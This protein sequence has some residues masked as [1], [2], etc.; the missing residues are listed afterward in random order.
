GYSLLGVDPDSVARFLDILERAHGLS[1]SAQTGSFTRT[2]DALSTLARVDYSPTERHTISLRGY[3]SGSEVANTLL[4]PLELLESGA[5]TS[6]RAYGVAGTLTSRLGTSWVNE[7]R[8]SVS[9]GGRDFTS[10]LAAPAGR[11]RVLSPLEE[12]GA[13]VT[14]LSFGGDPVPPGETSERSIEVADELSLLV[15]GTHRIKL[16]SSFAHTAFGQR[17]AVGSNGSFVFASLADLEAGRAT[18]FTRTLPGEATRGSGWSAALYLGDTWRP[19]EPLQLVYGVRV[20]GSGFGASPAYSPAA[21]S[22]FGLHTDRIPAEVHVSPRLG[23]SWFTDGDRPWS[24]RGGI[25]EFRGRTPFSLYA[26]VLNAGRGAGGDAFLSCVGEGRVPTTD[27]R[28]F[29]ADRS[30]V[31]TTCADGSAG[32]PASGG[33]PNVAAFSSGFRS[34]RSW[35][36]SLGYDATLRQRLTLSM[37]A[38]YILGVSQYGVRDLNLASAPAFTL[39]A[40]GGR[41]VFAP[42]AAIDP[43]TGTIPLFASRRDGRFAQA[44]EVHSGLRSETGALTVALNGMLSSIQTNF[45]LSYTLS[46]TRDQS[47]F[48]F[49]GPGSGFASTVTRGDPNRPGW[50]PGDEDRRH[51][52][53]A[54][55]GRPLGSAWEVSLIGRA[56]SGAPYTPRVAGDVNGD[57][58]SNDAAFVFDPASAADAGLGAAMQRLLE[59]APEHAAACLRANL[60]GIV[61]RNGCRTGWEHSLDVRVAYTPTIGSL[62]RRLSIGMDVGNVPAGLDLLLHGDRG[63][64]GW[65]QG[66]SLADDVLLHPRGFDPGTR[67]FRYEVNERFGQTGSRAALSGSPF[68][69]QLS[70][71]LAVGPNPGRD[72]WGGFIGL[73]LGGRDGAIRIVERLPPQTSPPAGAQPGAEQEG[74]LDRLIPRP[75]EGIL[76]L[77][78]TLGLSAEQAERLEA[79]RKALEETNLPIRAELGAAL[80]A[81]GGAPS[82]NPGAV[83]DKLGPRVNQGRTHVQDALDRARA[84]LTP[85]QWGRVPESVRNAVAASGVKIQ[86]T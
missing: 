6:S 4:R 37:D 27:F 10:R 85:E 35:R 29:R 14:T 7:L 58:A 3:A 79:I 43:G 15:L 65:G 78:D 36:A 60:G 61:R 83:F 73:G 57:G 5:G 68:G 33:R 34:P 66:G 23:F 81:A 86:G 38:F 46:R 80:G 32:V 24:L 55:V 9:D 50:A 72:V 25:G 56:V 12:G 52:L 22:A 67:G 19:M 31:P 84:V 49:G 48:S 17:D 76:A 45:Q 21:D 77:R 62:G 41:P 42:A 70:A 39:D 2:R 69:I 8:A 82:G 54:V 53:S 63:L 18:S 71:R 11:V 51:V 47:S 28:R 26:E 75:I 16:G 1:T 59:A 13:G 40:E 30:S 20:E 64:R 74:T 44:Y